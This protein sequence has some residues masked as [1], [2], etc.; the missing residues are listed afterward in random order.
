MGFI[1]ISIKAYIKKHL[2]NNPGKNEKDIRE[3]Q[4]LTRLSTN[5][6]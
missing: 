3:K 4:K 2:R 1:P 6:V 5:L